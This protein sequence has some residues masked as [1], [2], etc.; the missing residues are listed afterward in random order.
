MPSP[1]ERLV[2]LRKQI[3]AKRGYRVDYMAINSWA[4]QIDTIIMLMTKDE[5]YPGEIK[6]G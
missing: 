2:E 4:A 6:R 3:Q 1:R 5:P